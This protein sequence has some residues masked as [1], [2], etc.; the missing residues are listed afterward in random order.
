MW[1]LVTM[2]DKKESEVAKL[3]LG[4]TLKTILDKNKAIAAENKKKGIKDT[5]LISSFGKLE[6]NTGLRKATIVDIVTAKR[7]AE[8]ASVAAILTA[9]EISFSEFGSLY[10]AI[11]D[12]QLTSFKQELTKVKK[13]RTQKKK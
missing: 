4:L 3:R 8:F 11:T 9:F 5:N 2:I 6:T 1:V 7:K 13:E 12:N 10:D